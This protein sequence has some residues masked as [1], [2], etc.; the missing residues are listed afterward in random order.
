MDQRSSRQ[1][2]AA[3]RLLA[4]RP[5]GAEPASPGRPCAPAFRG[6]VPRREGANPWPG[7]AW[8]LLAWLLAVSRVRLAAVQREVFG[9]E[10]TMAFVVAVLMPV[11]Q[12]RQIVAAARTTIAALRRVRMGRRNAEG[13]EADTPVRHPPVDPLH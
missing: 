8:T 2:E 4:F 9:A 10:A 5:R 11:A 13:E 12:G 3:G 1:V 7:L 6:V